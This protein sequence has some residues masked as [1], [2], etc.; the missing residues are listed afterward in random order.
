MDSSSS[1]VILSVLSGVLINCSCWS[2]IPPLSLSITPLPSCV[3]LQTLVSGDWLMLLTSF[4]GIPGAECHWEN[5]E[6][7]QNVVLLV[8]YWDL[9]VKRMGLYL[10]PLKC[11]S[12]L[13]V[14]ISRW[15]TVLESWSWQLTWQ[16][17]IIFSSLLFCFPSF[18]AGKW[19]DIKEKEGQV[20]RGSLWGSFS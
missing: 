8:E 1:K 5:W 14:S 12:E 2:E 4:K 20:K 7:L 15:F 3:L 10:S 18:H 11:V 19:E 16:T 6:V 17:E 9:A 13:S